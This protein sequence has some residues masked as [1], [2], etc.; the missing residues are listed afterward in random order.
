VPNT[1][2]ILHISLCEQW[3]RT[4]TMYLQI[5]I[6]RLQYSTE[7]ICA[8]IGDISSIQWELYC[9]LGAEYTAHPPVYAMWSVVPDIYNAFTAP[10]IQTS[11]FIWTYLRCNWRYLDNSMRVIVQTLCQI[12]RTPSSSRYVNC[13]P[14]HIQCKYSTAYSGF[15]VKLNGSALLLEI[16]RQC[17]ARYSA[18]LVR[19][20]AYI[21]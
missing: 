21:L 18:N 11:M 10:R 19:N 14:G 8:A 1:A 6:F 7:R 16:S 3:S 15:N 13:G 17:Y 12:L 2:H 20:T 4:Y 5:C 9:N